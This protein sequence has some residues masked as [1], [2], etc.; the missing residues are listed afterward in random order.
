MNQR[1]INYIAFAILGL[2][3]LG[4]GAALLYQPRNTTAVW[5]AFRGW[6]GWCKR[7]SPC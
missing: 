5:Q 6:P 3:W 7:W 4:F 2:L 1:L